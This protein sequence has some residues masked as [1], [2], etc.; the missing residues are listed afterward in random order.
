M[1]KIPVSKK[2]R[3]PANG[4]GASNDVSN[5]TGIVSKPDQALAAHKKSEDTKQTKGKKKVK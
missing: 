4:T 1:A 3:F 2:H 5:K